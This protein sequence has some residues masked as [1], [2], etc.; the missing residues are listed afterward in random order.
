MKRITFVIFSF[1]RRR[2]RHFLINSCKDLW[3]HLSLTTCFLM[4]ILVLVQQDENRQAAGC[5]AKQSFALSPKGGRF[6][7]D[8]RPLIPDPYF[9]EN[10]HVT[11]K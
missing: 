3:F 11:S 5:G 9:Q 2:G 4:S 7:S 1:I 10:I 8:P 6:F